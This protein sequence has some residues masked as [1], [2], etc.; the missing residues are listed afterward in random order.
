MARR[1][2]GLTYYIGTAASPLLC[3]ISRLT[4]CL[5]D[6]SPV[7]GW[8]LLLSSW[9]LARLAVHLI[10][11][12]RHACRPGG[13]AVAQASLMNVTVAFVPASLV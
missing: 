10:C 9:N 1:G 6:I 11:A 7:R 13:P 8:P 3:P 12:L 4:T 2:G 5:F